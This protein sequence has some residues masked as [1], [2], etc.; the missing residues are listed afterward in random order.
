MRA[1]DT[2]AAERERKRYFHGLRD[3]L[4]RGKA[5]ELLRLLTA[6]AEARASRPAQLSALA[7]HPAAQTLWTHVFYIEAHQNTMDYPAYRAKGWPV[8]SGTIE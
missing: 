2:P 6:E 8:G 1:G 4:D 3:R 5:K 7:E